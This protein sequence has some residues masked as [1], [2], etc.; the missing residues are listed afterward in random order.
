MTHTNH[1][2]D[3][4]NGLVSGN[5]NGKGNEIECVCV[6]VIYNNAQYCGRW[7]K[8]MK[9]MWDSMDFYYS[10]V[11]RVSDLLTNQCEFVWWV[12]IASIVESVK[13][14]ACHFE[15]HNTICNKASTQNSRNSI[16]DEIFQFH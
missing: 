4:F 16:F 6:C 3:Y 2:F 13:N 7:S 12:I 8:T 15:C 5:F 11:I 9:F 1:N 10:F 14:A